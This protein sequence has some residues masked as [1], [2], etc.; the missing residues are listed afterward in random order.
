M[1][2]SFADIAALSGGGILLGPHSA[3]YF[4]MNPFEVLGL[5]H[6][7]SRNVA[8]LESFRQYTQTRTLATACTGCL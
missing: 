1:A 2:Q 5:T 3:K 4:N 8:P 6:K 7:T